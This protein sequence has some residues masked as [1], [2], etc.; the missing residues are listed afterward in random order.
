[1]YKWAGNV[2]EDA[3]KTLCEEPGASK[4]LLSRAELQLA[5]GGGSAAEPA[6]AQR[7][8]RKL[9]LPG[10][11]GLALLVRA[12]QELAQGRGWNQQTL[13]CTRFYGVVHRSCTR[14][15]GSVVHAR[16]GSVVHADLFT[17]G[18]AT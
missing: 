1:M 11:E 10:Y 12:R 7:R 5:Q 15:S 16:P 18:I 3:E 9:D 4:L 13:H 8:F 2:A 6:E 17:L 14:E